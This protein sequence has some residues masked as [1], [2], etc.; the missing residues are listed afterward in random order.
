M[1]ILRNLKQDAE[2][3]LARLRAENAAL[4][5]ARVSRPFTMK[6]GQ[7]GGMSVYMGSRYPTTLYYEQ[8]LHLLDHKEEILKWLEANKGSMKMRDA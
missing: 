8:W 4:K 7:A 2:L 3:E 1:A 6:I 5:E